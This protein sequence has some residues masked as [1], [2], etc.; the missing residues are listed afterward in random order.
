MS[1]M[2]KIDMVKQIIGLTKGKFFTIRFVKKDGSL[3]EMTCRTGVTRH[4]VDNPRICSNGTSNTVAHIPK[5]IKVFDMVKNE[6]R[7]VNTD[8]LQYF[9]CGDIEIEIK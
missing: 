3:R 4:L 7:N 8:T 1:K 5:Y 2:S 6:Y 9:K